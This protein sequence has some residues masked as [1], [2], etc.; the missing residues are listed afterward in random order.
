ME[1]KYFEP[2]LQWIMTGDFILSTTAADKE[3][4]P[5]IVH[6]DLDQ[7]LVKFRQFKRK[8]AEMR[9]DTTQEFIG[10]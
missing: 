7:G 5:Y 10:T 6:K 8:H 9:L 3:I 2:C 4:V 1:V